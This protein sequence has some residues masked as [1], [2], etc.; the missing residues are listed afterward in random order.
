MNEGPKGSRSLRAAMRPIE[1]KGYGAGN[2]ALP[3][4]DAGHMI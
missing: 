3:P 2:G 4:K 1:D